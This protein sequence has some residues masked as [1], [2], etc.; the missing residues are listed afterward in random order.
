MARRGV[1]THSLQGGGG[2][3]VRLLHATNGIAAV[4]GHARF[5]RLARR[6]KGRGPVRRQLGCRPLDV[7]LLLYARHVLCED[8]RLGVLAI[9]AIAQRPQAGLGGLCVDGREVSVAGVGDL[10]RRDTLTPRGLT[11]GLLLAQGLELR[12]RFARALPRGRQGREGFGD[13]LEA[14]DEFLLWRR[15]GRKRGWRR[16]WRART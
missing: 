7:Q 14:T 10:G 3:G 13:G 4:R 11:D 12:L 6:P 9:Q 1:L 16:R 5:R 2:R 15:G 8:G